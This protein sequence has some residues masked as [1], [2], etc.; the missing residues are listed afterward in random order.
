MYFYPHIKLALYMLLQNFIVKKA[1]NCKTVQNKL[2]PRSDNPKLCVIYFTENS[3][4]NWKMVPILKIFVGHCPFVWPFMAMSKKIY[5]RSTNPEKSCTFSLL[6]SIWKW[7]IIFNDGN[8]FG[9]RMNEIFQN[10]MTEDVHISIY[11]HLKQ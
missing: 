11:W 10:V 5:S 6:F 3:F 8:A 2:I 1:I 9:V 4:L 7:F